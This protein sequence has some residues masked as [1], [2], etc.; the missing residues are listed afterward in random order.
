MVWDSWRE[1]D[2]RVVLGLLPP[3]FVG[4][5]A[6]A[7]VLRVLDPLYIRLAVGVIVVFSA[8]L[9][10]RDIRIPGAHTR[11]ATMISGSLSGALSTST[12]LAGPPIVLLFASRDLP[13]LSFR[14]SS[15]MYFLVLSV[16]G[17]FALYSRG[18]VEPREIPLSLGLIPA[19]LLGKAAGTAL[20]RRIS[21]RT[22]RLV[23]LSVV[24]LTGALGVATA[25]RGLL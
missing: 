15:A 22:F 13:K 14:G 4:I 5:F 3:A 25:L 19:A 11:W 21:E 6:G 12:G 20:L 17:L 24:I 18:L 16:V 1:A 7:E 8:L 9:L 23:A 2:R 10:L